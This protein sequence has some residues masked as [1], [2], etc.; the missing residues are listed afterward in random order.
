MINGGKTVG[1]TINKNS[2]IFPA[3]YPGSSSTSSTSSSPTSSSSS[4]KSP[5]SATSNPTASASAAQGID[6][7]AKQP[8]PSTSRFPSSA[9]GLGLGLG[10]FFGALLTLL[11]IVLFGCYRRSK[12]DRHSTISTDPSRPQTGSTLYDGPRSKFGV[13]SPIPIALAARTDFL[14]RDPSSRLYRTGTKVKSWFSSASSPRHPPRME[15]MPAYDP[16]QYR[17]DP[18]HPASHWKTPISPPDNTNPSLP[19]GAIP[20]STFPHSHPTHSSAPPSPIHDHE[21]RHHPSNSTSNSNHTSSH[22]NPFTSIPRTPPS[23]PLPSPH[24]SFPSP[25]HSPTSPSGP[26]TPRTLHRPDSAI[27]TES[28]KI[29][30]PPSMLPP[31]HPLH[32]NIDAVGH[33]YGSGSGRGVRSPSG[34]LNTLPQRAFE[35]PGAAPKPLFAEIQRPMGGNG[36]GGGAGNGVLGHPAFLDEDPMKGHGRRQGEGYGEGERDR[37]NTTFTDIMHRAG[38]EGRR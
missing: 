17:A 6:S 10:L 28:I 20:L 32:H 26:L 19:A 14:R 30:T 5:T 29:Y 24:P 9:V 38:F 15:T 2:T 13:S 37:P 8:H 1:C 4:T 31:A 18:T 27:E 34:G 21:L 22:N 23:P 12:G 7:N 33:D 25:S 16:N 3:G 36:A 11:A 35:S